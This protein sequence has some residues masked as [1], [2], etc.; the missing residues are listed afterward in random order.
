MKITAKVIDPALMQ[1]IKCLTMS[2]D[3]P[4]PPLNWC[5]LSNLIHDE[6][7]ILTLEE[8]LSIIKL[9]ANLSES[10]PSAMKLLTTYLESFNGLYA[11]RIYLVVYFKYIC[12]Y[13]M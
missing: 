1:S 2:F 13:N 5:F 3:K 10:S 7:L 6:E 11:V 8:K 12:I 4:L 9:L